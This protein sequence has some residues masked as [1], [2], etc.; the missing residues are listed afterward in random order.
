VTEK[1]KDSRGNNEFEQ[2]D[3][4]FDIVIFQILMAKKKKET[5]YLNALLSL[6]CFACLFSIN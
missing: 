6:L 3:N 5:V 2:I 1:D 4:C